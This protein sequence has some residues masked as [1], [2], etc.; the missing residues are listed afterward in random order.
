[1]PHFIA[2]IKP[3]RTDFLTNP[4]FEEQE[5][6]KDHFA[7]LK[8]LLAEKKLFIAGPTLVKEDP[9]GFIIF[10]VDTIESA[11]NILENDPSVK[12]GIQEI[13][14]IREIRISLYQNMV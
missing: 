1:M 8:T 11:K 5:I 2:Q 12:S 6:M 13:Q 14:Y 10:Q 7:Y 9:W 3:Y 4:K